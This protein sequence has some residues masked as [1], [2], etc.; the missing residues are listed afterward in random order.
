MAIDERR[1]ETAVDD[2]WKCRVLGTRREPGNGGVAFP[3]GPNVQA[4]GVETPAAVTVREVVRI[5][6]LNCLHSDVFHI[7][8][9]TLQ[10]P[11]GCLFRTLSSFAPMRLSSPLGDS[12]WIA[13]K[14]PV[15][16]RITHDRRV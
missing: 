12:T 15:R 16:R 7:P 1:N 3:D 6:V 2:S 10:L 9:A 4:D 14:L 13:V 5:E 8:R 11:S